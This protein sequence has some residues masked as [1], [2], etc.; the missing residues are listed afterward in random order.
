[1]TGGG[2]PSWT[3][4]RRGH[5]RLTRG[6]GVRR[7]VREAVTVF[8]L[9]VGGFESCVAHTPTPTLGPH[10]AQDNPVVV[11]SMPEAVRIE[12]V[13]P[14]PAR[15]AVWVDGFWTWAGRRWVWQQGEWVRPPLGAYYARPSLV[16]LPVP[17]YEETDAGAQPIGYAMQ[18]LFI[19]GHW[20]LPDGSVWQPGRADSGSP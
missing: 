17:A 2:G 12:V 11:T 9:C 15:D 7:L 20:H 3:V 1:M 6:M 4:L 10:T 14:Q 16:R 8:L 5:E 18:I 13:P 19:P